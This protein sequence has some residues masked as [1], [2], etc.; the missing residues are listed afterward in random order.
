M[1]QFGK[2][3]ELKITAAKNSHGKT[4]VK[5]SFFTAP[6]KIMKP[7]ERADGGI[8]IFQQSASAGVMAGDTQEF[9]FEIQNGAI[10][11]IAS[12][13][14]EKIFKM[15]DDENAERKITAEVAPDAKFIYTPLPCIPFAG[16]NFKSRAKINLADKSSKL[17][18]QDCISCGRKAHGELFDYKKYQ[19]LVE[20]KCE[21]KLVFRDNLSF[22]GSDCGKNPIKKL[23][24]QSETMFRN[25]SHLGSMVIFNFDLKPAD[26]FEILEIDEKLLYTAE[27][28]EKIKKNSASL[29][30]VTLTEGNGIAIKILAN[31]AEEIQN[32]FEKITEFLSDF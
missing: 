23:I 28:L 3:S 15:E 8:K 7:F 24:L 19:N 17:I 1:N 14:F 10:L 4:F 21:G 20:I 29:A 18:Y 22:E 11:E 30:S 6:F 9:S 31:S 12:Q 27:N 25:F 5:D 13:S 32:L 16:S 26:F 2:T